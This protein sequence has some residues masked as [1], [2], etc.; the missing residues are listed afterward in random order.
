MPCCRSGLGCRPAGSDA[1]RDGDPAAVTDSHG[2]D[3][4]VP[5]GHRDPWTIADRYRDSGSDVDTDCDIDAIGDSHIDANGNADTSGDSDADRF[6]DCIS[7]GH[8]VRDSHGVAD[9]NSDDFSGRGAGHAD[10][11]W[12][13]GA[14]KPNGGFLRVLERLRG[15]DVRVPAGSRCLGG[16]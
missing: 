10:R 15:C 6:R 9:T 16:V 2:H 5:N 12:S 3:A 13:V 11:L 1:D 4:A 8:T 7:V 14:N